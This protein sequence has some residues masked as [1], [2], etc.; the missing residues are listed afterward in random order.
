[1]F[2]NAELLRLARKAARRVLTASADDL[3]EDLAQQAVLELWRRQQKG[4]AIANPDALVQTI[5]RRRAMRVRDGWEEDRRNIESLG[6]TPT[7]GVVRKVARRRME[8]LGVSSEVLQRAGAD[9]IR[10]AIANL[11]EPDRTIAQLTFLD[12]MQAPE[13]GVQLG[14]AAKTVRNRL[15]SIRRLLEDVLRQGD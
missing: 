1:M 14:L 13:V 3:A 7:G 4:I 5:A 15:V 11:S 8:A 9:R 2:E 6:E 12:A 10:A